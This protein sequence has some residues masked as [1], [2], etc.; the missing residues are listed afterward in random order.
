MKRWSLLCF[1]LLLGV[2]PQS[3][4]AQRS[5]LSMKGPKFYEMLAERD[6]IYERTLGVLQTKDETD[7]WKDQE[8]Y[9]KSLAAQHPQAF[10][11][12]ITKK[13]AVYQEHYLACEVFC[14]NSPTYWAK[15]K[16][17]LEVPTEI[18]LFELGNSLSLVGSK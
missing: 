3:M 4:S 13:K 5:H 16:H 17:Y 2:L 1:V 15:V 14:V 6:A 9:E 12:Y 11:W 10:T 8:V 18:K 7:Y